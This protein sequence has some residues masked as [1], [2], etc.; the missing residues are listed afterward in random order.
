MLSTC[1]C[2]TLVLTFIL[3]IVVGKINIT[4]FVS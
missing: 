3:N 4:M 1:I 2:V